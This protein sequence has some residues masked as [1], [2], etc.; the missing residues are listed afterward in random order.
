MARKK[1]NRFTKI[2][3]LNVSAAAMKQIND[4]K[5]SINSDVYNFKVGQGSM[6]RNKNFTQDVDARSRFEDGYKDGLE[7]A[8][9]WDEKTAREQEL[10]YAKMGAENLQSATRSRD[11]RSIRDKLE[12]GAYWTGRSF[13]THAGQYAIKD[14]KKKRTG[15]TAKKQAAAKKTSG[16]KGG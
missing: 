13:G 5:N 1:I 4:Y 12:N 7:A 3:D 8:T 10:L 2:G 16:R 6:A 14:A 9:Y 11:A 15:S